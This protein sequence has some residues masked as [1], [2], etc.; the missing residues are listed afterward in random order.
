MARKAVGWIERARLEAGSGQSERKG[1]RSI[2]TE[3][4]WAGQK[5]RPACS[6]TGGIQ[7]AAGQPSVRDALRW[8]PAMSRGLDWMA[9]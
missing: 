3:K 9:L 1:E 7:E 4:D 5:A 6:H 2:W 8:I